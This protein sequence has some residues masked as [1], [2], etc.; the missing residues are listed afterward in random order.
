M[1]KKLIIAKMLGFAI[2]LFIG[3]LFFSELL[4]EKKL[5]AG[6]AVT[7]WI[8]D[9]AELDDN[10]VDVISLGT[11]Q[12]FCSL[13]PLIL[14]EEN[15]I[16]SYNLASSAAD[17]YASK[18]Y[19]QYGLET[20]APKIV[21][22]ECS[23]LIREGTTSE[24]WNRRAYDNLPFSLYK[25]ENLWYSMNEDEN[26]VSYLFPCLRFHERWNDLTEA[27]FKW[28]FTKE[29]QSEYTYKGYYPRYK[30]TNADLS[31]F[32]KEVMNFQ[33]AERASDAVKE[34]KELCDESGATLILW[35]SP[36]PMWRITYKEAVAELANEIGV[37]YLDLNDYI[38][39]IGIDGAI[40]FYD[41]NAHLNDSGATKVSR[42]LASFLG[43]YN[44]GNHK[45]ERVYQDYE[46]NYR[47]YL[48]DKVA[49]ITEVKS[50]VELISSDSRYDLFVCV[51]D[52]LSDIKEYKEIL[53][54]LP[55][56]NLTKAAGVASYVG[57]YSD[58]VIV[59]ECNAKNEVFWEG[60]VS[61]NKVELLS[62]G[63]RVGD[64]GSIIIDGVEYMLPKQRGLGIVVYDK[65]LE[66]VVDSVTFDIKMGAKAYR[67]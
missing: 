45:E 48:A 51:N 59:D 36:S 6:E 16:A 12:A 10:T 37:E 34:I 2:I 43:K 52:G 7:S 30:V 22:L 27:D 17:I 26:M 20:Q 44:L 67:K 3:S 18:A 46:E 4:R 9:Y 11:S 38:D 50:Y 15:G 53:S 47:N 19:L 24:E 64:N 62:Q 56:E 60:V 57:V 29:S 42:Y 49:R 63:Y 31:K 66:C 55:F 40:D 25:F 41:S 21:L 13:N 58:G 23:R 5:V 32:E 65:M 14:W 8:V 54:E 35:K 33:I 61:G 28:A 39:E 1:K